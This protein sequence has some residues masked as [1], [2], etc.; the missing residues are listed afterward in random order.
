MVPP[1]AAW[2]AQGRGEI[3]ASPRRMYTHGGRGRG[4]LSPNLLLHVI[5]SCITLMMTDGF[6]G[7]KLGRL[8]HWLFKSIA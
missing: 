6:S 4:L 8:V 7:E 5:N 3:L 1:V 2:L